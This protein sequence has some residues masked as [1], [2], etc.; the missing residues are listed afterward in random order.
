MST[1]IDVEDDFRDL[2]PAARTEATASL[3]SQ[4]ADRMLDNNKRIFDRVL[5]M[6]A[7]TEGDEKLHL[8]MLATHLAMETSE[9]VDVKSWNNTEITSLSDYKAWSRLG[10]DSGLCPWKHGSSEYI[11]TFLGYLQKAIC[12]NASRDLLADAAETLELPIDFCEFL[13]HTAGVVYPNL[14]RQMFVCSFGTNTYD[15]Q[16]Q[17]QPLDKICR[18][19][20]P[21]GFTV[22]AGWAAGDNDRSCWIHYL[23]CRRVT[24]P[25]GPW[26]WR[27]FINNID[28]HDRGYYESL[29]D[30]LSWYCNAYDWVDWEAVQQGIATLH[31]ECKEALEEE[32]DEEQTSE[33]ETEEQT[34]DEESD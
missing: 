29:R 15:I 19:A 24:E 28:F 1:A 8:D 27:I 11:T 25:D 26:R 7:E 9:V 32:E 20:G 12:E 22:A 23:L 17:A 21:D 30:F 2:S 16:G 3:L 13:K 4:F 18:V 33:E 5:D 34:S 31:Q 6:I 14:D 10:H